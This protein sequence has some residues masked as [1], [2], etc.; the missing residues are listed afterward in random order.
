MTGTQRPR[1]RR[2][3]RR[4]AALLTLVGLLAAACSTDA[5]G[6]VAP[7]STGSPEDMGDMGGMGTEPS[8]ESMGS[9]ESVGA[10]RVPAV[11]AWY[12]EEAVAFI[13]TEVSDESIAQLLEG[14]MGSPVP[15]VESLALM[16]SEG[17]STVYVFMNG[18]VPEDT[19]TGPTGFQPDVFDTVPGDDAYTP[20]REIVTVTWNDVDRARLLTSTAEIEAAE[21]DGLIL[22]E[23]TGIVV[24]AP[25]LTWPGGQR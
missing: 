1:S 7:T 5:T 21:G 20:L 11:F 16:P 19:P 18:V 9:M 8:T 12:E 3:L 23:R 24:N 10:P 15:V 25:M 14:M 17:L 4:V 13:H 22:L 6:P 2:R